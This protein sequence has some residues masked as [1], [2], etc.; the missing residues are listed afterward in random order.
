M[1]NFWKKKSATPHSIAFRIFVIYIIS[2]LLWIFFSD[3]ILQ[4]LVSTPEEFAYYSIYKGWTYI[5]LTSLLLYFLVRKTWLNHISIETSLHVSEDRWKFA[6]E[7]AGDGVWDW[8]M[9]TDQV[10]RSSRWKEI[11]GYTTDE[12]DQTASAGRK[13]VHPDDLTQMLEDT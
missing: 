2:G 12:L 10:F 1:K 5:T 8:D 4:T 13:L 11:Y 3:K 7:G 6:L 9:R